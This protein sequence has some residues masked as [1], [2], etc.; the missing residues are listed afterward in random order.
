MIGQT[1]ELFDSAVEIPDQAEREA[2]LKRACTGNP[3]LRVRVDELLAAHAEAEHFFSNYPR[4]LHTLADGEFPEIS[5]T[6]EK[7]LAGSKIGNYKLLQKIGEGG[8]GVVYMA[9]QD[10][11]VRRR[12]AL[13]II[14]LGMD[15]KSVIARF[16]SERQALAMM[17]HPNIARVF[18]AG[19][20]ETGRPFFVMELIHGIGILEYCDK[21]H[22]DTRRRLELFMQVCHAIQHAHQKGIVHRDIKPSNILVTLND[23]VPVPKVID[24]G[25]AKA[26][27]EQLT[28]KT[29]FTVYGCFIGTPAYMSPEQ[30]EFSEM[31]VD[32][33]SDIY[34]L[35]VLLYELLTGKTPFD[36][37]DLMAS[38]LDE[39]RRTLRE[40]EPHRPSYKLKTMTATELT[41]TALHRHIDTPKLQLMLKGDLD[42]IVMKALE[43]DRKRRYETANGLG[44]DISRFLN[45]E[46]I[47]ARPPSRWYRFKKL[48]QRNRGLFAAAGAVTLA[49]LIGL[50]TSTWLL[51]KERE[52]RR[53]AVAAEQQAELSRQNEIQLRRE[54]E[55]RADIARAAVMLSRGQLAEAQQLV[56]QLQ[57]PVID[58]SLEAVGVFRTL[59]DWAASEG[60]WAQAVVHFQRLNLADQ[61]DKTEATDSSAFDLLRLGP[62][63]IAAGDLAGYQDFVKKCIASFSSVTSSTA[64]ERI[65]KISLIC[66]ADSTNIHALE[67]LAGVLAQSLDEARPATAA[68]EYSNAWREFSLSL[69]EYRCGDFT[70]SIMWQ[71]KCLA[72]S[73]LLPERVA[74]AH[75]VLAMAL[76]QTHQ[77][78]AAQSELKQ[79]QDLVHQNCP[80]AVG[81]FSI[82]N[83]PPGSTVYWY[84]WVSAQILQREAVGLIK[85]V[86]N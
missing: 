56:D 53:R 28:D 82:S 43:K 47:L 46:P 77:T 10:K 74:M 9:G 2:M 68:D 20:T 62:T 41:A 17:D 38:G 18:D 54:A 59:G 23:G 33:R 65:I 30:A 75:F 42:W 66:P 21:N 45:N 35:G 72:S 1:R 44:L 36:Q 26:M 73:S 29:L 83:M 84:D 4:P 31:D 67:P 15:T 71:K 81:K 63:L 32:T 51:A 49:L 69:Y 58:P 16:E 79:G 60:R 24:F 7:D 50:G 19:A 37:K 78:N 70:N 14:K 27:A 57:V 61:V 39:M 64:A 8:C 3:E 76:Y 22:M 6:G 86:A 34:S 5:P 52:M 40:R 13:K 48:A 55:A 25:I 80:D 85:P 11:P 12:V